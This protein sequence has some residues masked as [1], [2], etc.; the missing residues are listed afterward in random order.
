MKGVSA[1]F[2]IVAPLLAAKPT[3][4]I[5]RNGQK[6]SVEASDDLT[7]WTAVTNLE[8]SEPKEFFKI[9]TLQAPP[10]PFLYE[11]NDLRSVPPEYSLNASPDVEAITDAWGT[12]DDQGIR[13]FFDPFT[14]KIFNHPVLQARYALSLLNSYRL[15]TNPIYLERAERHGQR[16]IDTHFESRGAWFFKYDFDYQIDSAPAPGDIIRAP[17]FSALSQ[18][19]AISAFCELYRVTT[20]QAYLDAAAQAFAAY[21]LPASDTEPWICDIDEKGC[22]WM[23]EYAS[24]PKSHQWVM[25]GHISG[26]WG[27]YDYYR[28]TGDLDALR[29][30][31]GGITTVKLWCDYFRT[32][33]A[34]AKYSRKHPNFATSYHPLRVKMMAALYSISGDPFFAKAADG[35]RDEC[36]DPTISSAGTIRGAMTGFK[37]DQYGQVTNTIAVILPTNTTTQ[38]TS[39]RTIL[40]QPGIWLLISSGEL[41]GYFVREDW[42][43]AQMNCIFQEIA[44][45]PPRKVTV[46]AG[47][48][49]YT[50]FQCDSNGKQTARLW[51][52][53]PTDAAMEFDKV[54]TI[55]SRTCLHIS[56]GDFAGFWLPLMPYR[57][58]LDP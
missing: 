31:Q 53:F 3:L 34:A 45:Y 4:T 21:K 48:P 25:N 43:T 22:L 37:F 40:E 11:T 30:A 26:V 58:V 36:P 14:G 55:N 24:V 12:Q 20:N 51:K 1:L 57:M 2:F 49:A 27:A 19:L 6:V 47:T 33:G 28:T 54:A 52:Y 46:G 23:E 38:I 29:L 35:M 50:P 17:W 44:F 13:M 39:R 10:Y 18:G 9:N 32:P 16:L 5:Q 8:I 7:R 41:D 15:T 56:A 42:L